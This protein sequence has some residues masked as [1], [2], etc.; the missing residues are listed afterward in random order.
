MGLTA[1]SDEN[2]KQLISTMEEGGLN[3]KTPKLPPSVTF[4]V[5]G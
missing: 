3:P 1:H 4:M 2:T 5:F